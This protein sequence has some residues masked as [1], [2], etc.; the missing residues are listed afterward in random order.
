MYIPHNSIFLKYHPS[1]Q[2]RK[3][4]P[5]FYFKILAR[6]L[7]V[8]ERPTEH[9]HEFDWRITRVVRASGHCLMDLRHLQNYID[10]P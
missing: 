4:P 7:D 6:K 1:N 10:C 9:T 3:A 2:K 8:Y 5:R